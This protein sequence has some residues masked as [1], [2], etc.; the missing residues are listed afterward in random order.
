[1]IRRTAV[2]ITLLLSGCAFEGASDSQANLAGIP[3]EVSG[4]GLDAHGEFFVGHVSNAGG[5]AEGNWLHLGDSVVIGAGPLDM[6]LCWMNGTMAAEIQGP[7]YFNGAAGYTYRISTRMGYRP[8]PGL[9]EGPAEVQTVTSTRRYRPTRWE[10]GEVTIEEQARVTIP[11]ELPVTVGNAGNQWAWLTFQ[12][13]DEWDL[14]TCRYRGGASKPNPQNP[15]DIAAGEA[16]YFER[17]TGL[18][19]ESIEPGDRVDVRW[20]KLHVQSGAH[21]FPSRHDAQTTVSVD[22]EVTPLIRLEAQPDLYG[23]G[24]WDDATGERVYFR[25]GFLR[26]GSIEIRQLD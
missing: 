10:E 2:L 4:L 23:I 16:Y 21:F 8:E 20:M 6:L 9:V 13:A 12:R 22:L 3:C 14:V 26:S 18:R 24:V 15:S 1:M 25:D 19:G 5:T 11:A 7:A 17:C